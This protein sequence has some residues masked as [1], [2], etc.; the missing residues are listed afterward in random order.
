MPEVTGI[1]IA[2]SEVGEM[3]KRIKVHTFE[4]GLFFREGE[5]VGIREAGKYWLIDPLRKRRIDVVS[6]R[7]PWIEHEKLD[8]IVKSGAL[9]GM[10]EVLEIADRER[11]LVWIDGRFDRVLTPGLY[12][13]WTGVRKVGVERVPAESARFTHHEI[14]RILGIIPYDEVIHRDNLVMRL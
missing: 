1:T 14:A 4:K 12:A 10:A 3:I 7:T 6:M 13:L 9:A 2:I 5:F 8:V 11:A